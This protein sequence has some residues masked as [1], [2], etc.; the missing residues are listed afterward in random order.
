MPGVRISG[1][2]V[3]LTCEG[4]RVGTDG[5]AVCCGGGL[6]ELETVLATQSAPD[7]TAA[8][9]IEPILGEGG[10]YVP[11]EVRIQPN[12]C[13]TLSI[14]VHSLYAA[15]H[16]CFQ[17][18]LDGV[19]KICDKHNILMIMDEVQAGMGRTGH[20]WAHQ[21]L[22]SGKPDIIVFAK[23]IA[24]G[25][26]M[27][28]IAASP[29]LFKGCPPASLGGTYGGNPIAAAAACATLDVLSAE[30]LLQNARG[31]THLCSSCAQ[32]KPTR[33]LI[34]NCFFLQ[35]GV[36]SSWLVFLKSHKTTTT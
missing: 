1:Y 34:F 26:P 5:A 31:E 32:M 24:S 2:P 10:F 36:L 18:Y 28:G 8:V 27:G 17:G 33:L 35:T 21:A 19:R 9:L 13:A 11:P 23:G 3:C 16:L 4:K 6:R 29:E 14:A 12:M 7:E 20:W 15:V 25:L 30:D 22:M